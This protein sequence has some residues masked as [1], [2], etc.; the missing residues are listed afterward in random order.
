[1][2]SIIGFDGSRNQLTGRKIDCVRF[3]RNTDKSMLPGRVLIS[4]NEALD[5]AGAYPIGIGL[6]IRNYN[7]LVSALL[8]RNINLFIPAKARS[9]SLLFSLSCYSLN[10][11]E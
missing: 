2:D 8:K 4:Y 3:G 6:C 10:F 1:M 7:A 5:Y 11:V 9:L